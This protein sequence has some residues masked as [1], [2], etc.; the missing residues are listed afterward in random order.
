MNYICP[1]CGAGDSTSRAFPTT[2]FQGTVAE[3]YQERRARSGVV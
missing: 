3:A 1:Y 2:I